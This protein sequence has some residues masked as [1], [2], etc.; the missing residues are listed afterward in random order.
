V[1][2][3]DAAENTERMSHRNTQ[4]GG[5]AREPPLLTAGERPKAK[6]LKPRAWRGSVLR[7]EINL[8][9]QRV[10]RNEPS[11]I[12]DENRCDVVRHAERCRM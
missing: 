8:V 3:T 11:I 7:L 1:I 6:S 12:A 5:T 2:D 9:L 4:L 10:P